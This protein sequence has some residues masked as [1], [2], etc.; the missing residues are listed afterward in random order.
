MSVLAFT[1]GWWAAP[2]M[3]VAFNLLVVLCIEKV[4][5]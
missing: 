2:I 1:L 4:Q 3:L 5:P